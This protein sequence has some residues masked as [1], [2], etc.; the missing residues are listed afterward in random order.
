MEINGIA[1]IFLTVSNFAA[2]RLFY[3][4]LL[5]FLGM[6][7]VLKF[8]GL[9]LLRRRAYRGG[10]HGRGSAV[11]GRA[12]RPATHRLPPPLLSRPRAC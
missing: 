3:E 8:D 11:R 4:P 10:D 2:C 9:P 12:L 7:T 6:K 1:H 5:N